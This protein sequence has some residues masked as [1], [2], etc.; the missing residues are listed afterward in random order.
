MIAEGAHMPSRRLVVLDDEPLFREFVCEVARSCGF[1]TFD[2]GSPGVFES[3]LRLDRPHAIVLDLVMPDVD[4][5]EVLRN[6]SAQLVNIPILIASGM[7][8]R[9]LDTALR[10]GEARGLHM[11]GV[12]QKPIRAAALKKV[13]EQIAA[14][15]DVL[16]ERR[17]EEA[18]ERQELTLHYQ[19][20]LD[21]R[22][23]LIVGAEALIR[24]QHP[25]RGIVPPSAFIPMAEESTLIDRITDMVLAKAMGQAVKWSSHDPPLDISINLSAKNI[26]DVNFPDQVL[27]ICQEHGL[28]PAR[29][30][31]ELTETATMQDTILMMDVATRL[32]LKGFRLAIDD[33]GTG[34]SSLSQLQRLPFSEMKVDLS[35]VSTML[36]SHDSEIIVRTIINMA[37]NLGLRAVAEGV[38]NVATLE[39]LVEMG[40]DLAQGYLIA[41]PMPPEQFG[42]FLAAHTTRP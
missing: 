21:L 40:C 8:S 41:R 14:A 27:A 10:L 5:I 2:T 32:R 13:F 36:S 22:S 1:E 35:F 25:Q 30:V 42:P 20:Y 37:H 28:D 18:I 12:I 34:Y 33:F 38:E 39:R 3:R 24:W 31:F 26:R 29:V 15:D 19:P 11:A 16:T 9:L 17:L 7:D 6:L 23:R 4:G